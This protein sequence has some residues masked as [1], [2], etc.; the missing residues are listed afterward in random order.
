MRNVCKNFLYTHVLFG[1]YSHL[2]TENAIGTSPEQYISS[3]P[4]HYDIVPLKATL[5][6]RGSTQTRPIGLDPLQAV[7]RASEAAAKVRKIAKL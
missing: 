7:Q 2:Q 6:V 4:P 1:A 5:N 3:S